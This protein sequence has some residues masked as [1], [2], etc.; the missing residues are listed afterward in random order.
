[1]NENI[2]MENVH[3][4]SASSESSGISILVVMQFY[5]SQKIVQVR[6]KIDTLNVSNLVLTIVSLIKMSR[7]FAWKMP[8][9][10]Y[11]LR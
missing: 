4:S 5:L 7:K 3:S 11:H 8:C 9:I 1:V 10:Y 6:M 2:I